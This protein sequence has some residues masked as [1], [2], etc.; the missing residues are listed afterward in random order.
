MRLVPQGLRNRAA[1]VVFLVFAAASPAAAQSIVAGHWIGDAV[2]QGDHLPVQLTF[3]TM[4]TGWAGSFTAPTL[5]ALR[6]P[7]RNVALNGS[8]LTFDLIGDAGPFAFHGKLVDSGA[9]TGEWNLF[10]VN[11]T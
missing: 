3:E 10:G 5:R 9:L 7:L 11:A 6:Y 4:P 1:N 8:E 2:Y